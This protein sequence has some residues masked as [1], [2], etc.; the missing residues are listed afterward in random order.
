MIEAANTN[1]HPLAATVV[2][3]PDT[4]GVILS[5][6]I[7][8]ATHPWLLDHAVSGTILLPGAV[9]AELAVHA[10]DETGTP[11]LEEL[12]IGQ[13][14]VVP[15]GGALQLHVLVGVEEGGR[16][17]VR[18][19]S[20]ADAGGSWTE[21]ATGT[22]SAKSLL[23]ASD[24]AIP[25]PPAGAEAIALDGFYDGMA[26]AGYEY[27]PAFQG[28]RAVWRDGKDVVA[29]VAVPE[30]QAGVAGRFGIHPA[31]LDAALHVGSF[32]LPAPS[33]ERVTLLPFTWNDVQLHASGA[34]S[35]RVRASAPVG[36]TL[37]VSITDPQGVPVATIGSLELRAISAEQ[38]GALSPSAG[39]ESLHVVE[40]TEHSQVIPAE[41]WG[42]LGS[43][44]YRDVH[45]YAADPE[46][47]GVLLADVSTW[48][49]SEDPVARAH[50]LAAQALMLVQGWVTRPDLTEERLV[51]V[52]TGAV[53]RG[54]VPTDPAAAAVWGL[55]RS[56]QSEHPDR[57]VLVDADDRSPS[58]LA[59]AA[60]ITVSELVLRG[61]RAQT[62]RLVPAPA[63]QRAAAE[64]NPDGTVLITGGTGT[65]GALTARHLVSAHGTQHLLLT[66]RRG[67]DAPGAA[68][69]AAEL[70]V[71]VRI[72]ACDVTDRDALDGLLDSIP[73]EHPLTAVVHTAGALD[74]A[75]LTDLTPE[76]LAAVL[77]PKVDALLNLDTLTRAANPAVFAV[78][79][80]ATGV[81]GTAGQA[82]YAAAN[83]FAD[84]LVQ[85]RRDAGLSG[86]SLA[87][88]L[89]ADYSELS[90]GLGGT[91]RDRT[92]RGGVVPLTA[93]EGMALFDAVALRAD[94]PALTV[95]MTLDLA[96][97]RSAVSS[98][99]AVPTLLRTLVPAPRRSLAGQAVPVESLHTRLVGLSDEEQKA[100]LTELVR[101]HAAAVLG[102]GDREAVGPDDA[103]FEIGFDSMTAVQLRNRLAT[104]T[105]LRL[106]AAQ[107][108]DQ[109]TP[110]IAAEDLRDRL[111][112][113]RTAPADP[114]DER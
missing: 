7:A 37:T 88:G 99:D 111:A 43:D 14:V 36:Q 58:T 83:T 10:G 101:D 109:P 61:G 68:K 84:A 9:L 69:L 82:A 16:R 114:T 6:R 79:S 67:L 3:I 104:A 48:D 108:F 1:T 76:R 59:I 87:W 56:A 27:G 5:G 70:G 66:S 94:S 103:F 53:S 55:V 39:I 107:L 95:P 2:N 89:W 106:P 11:T 52:T 8:T 4:G 63:G 18:V 45:A 17:D 23:P 110:A 25:W 46:R 112:A 74:D 81:L 80:S 33:G 60:G 97:L 85:Q 41:R 29:E 42:V 100:V 31:L 47:P 19:Y 72:V 26:A 32:C 65:L 77:A 113:A 49:H 86:V 38:L 22:L 98:G 28:L 78:Y 62:P 44:Q 90:A 40:W 92:R 51:L 96:S 73:A 91:D 105:G 12:V 20:R 57:L 24:P 15:T 21:H 75:V 64:L 13:P 54:S 71:D 93:D 35:V 102:H 30:S 34:T 50:A